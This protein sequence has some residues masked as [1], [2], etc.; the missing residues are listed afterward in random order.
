MIDFLCIYTEYVGEILEGDNK[1]NVKKAMTI[2]DS[3]MITSTECFGEHKKYCKDGCSKCRAWH[4][5]D[6]QYK[7]LLAKTELDADAISMYRKKFYQGNAI[8]DY[9]PNKGD[10]FDDNGDM[11]RDAYLVLRLK[12]FSDALISRYFHINVTL[13]RRKLFPDWKENED[14]YLNTM[15]IKAWKKFKENKSEVV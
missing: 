10:F 6:L 5:Q 14:Y 12:E 13:E 11:R 4:T 8:C 7:A 3:I 1:V 9:F 15:A 2:L